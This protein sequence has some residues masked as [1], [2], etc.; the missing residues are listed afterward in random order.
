MSSR[1]ER[2]A[3]KRAGSI[4]EYNRENDLDQ[5]E[6]S[7]ARYIVV[8]G[9]KYQVMVTGTQYCAQVV[10]GRYTYGTT[11]EELRDSAVWMLAR[12][13]EEAGAAVVAAR[14]FMLNIHPEDSI[15][16][17]FVDLEG[18]EHHLVTCVDTPQFVHHVSVIRVDVNGKPEYRLRVNGEV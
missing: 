2:K 4:G 7:V 15:N 5:N 12:A 11:L 13:K 8:D 3:V 18:I 14:S 10:P 1:E 17:R 16:I 6:F 9:D